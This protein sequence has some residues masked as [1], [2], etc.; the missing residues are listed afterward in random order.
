MR[1]ERRMLIT[2]LASA[3][4]A[5]LV[6]KIGEKSLEKTADGVVSQAV[7]RTKQFLE[8]TFKK[9]DY[10]VIQ[11]ALEAARDDLL[12]QCVTDEQREHVE[13]VLATLFTTQAG[14]LLEKFSSQVSQVYL[15]PTSAPAQTKGLARTYRKMAG[16]VALLNGEVLLEADLANLLV[17]FFYAFRER[18]LREKDFSY[19]REYFQLAEARHQTEVQSEMRDLLAAI[20]ANTAR[21][22]TPSDDRVVREA[23]RAYLIKEYKDHTIRG[24]SPQIGGNV[25]SLPLSEIF[26]PLQAIEGQPAVAKYAEEDLLRQAEQ[27]AT[28]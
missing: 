27:E 21:D 8:E 28:E 26:L 22:A 12:S 6:T 18:L 1:T 2:A 25:L 16:P 9:G 23:Y 11:R 10:A 3:L 20:A 7:D 17:A 14:P 24:F 19:L 4:I 15:Q 5:S 13:Q